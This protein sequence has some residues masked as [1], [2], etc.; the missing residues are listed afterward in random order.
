VRSTLLG[1]RSTV[2]VFGSRLGAPSGDPTVGYGWPHVA[3]P[4]AATRESRRPSSLVTDPIERPLDASRSIACSLCRP[5]VRRRF[6]HSQMETGSTIQS[7]RYL[8]R[9]LRT[10]RMRQLSLFVGR[11]DRRFRSDRVGLKY[12][13]QSDSY[14]MYR[15]RIVVVFV[16]QSPK[17]EPREPKLQRSVID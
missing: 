2:S 4:T 11:V 9:L 16:Q 10:E 12:T 3:L 17:N 15:R 5:S 8:F 7:N 1:N 13:V 14:G 6:T